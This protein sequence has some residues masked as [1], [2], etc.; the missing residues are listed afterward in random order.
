MPRPRTTQG[1][2]EQFVKRKMNELAHADDLLTL[3][4]VLDLVCH[5]YDVTPLEAVK[6]IGHA[7]LH[8]ECFD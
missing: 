4:E 8:F 5:E 2:V 3:L 1:A 7:K 6:L